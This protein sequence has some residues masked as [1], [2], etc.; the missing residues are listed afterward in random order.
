MLIVKNLYIS[1]AVKIIYSHFKFAS[2]WL[3]QALFILSIIA[4]KPLTLDDY[5]YPN[6]GTVCGWLV[7]C[8]SIIPIPLYMIYRFL[9]KVKGPIRQVRIVLDSLKLRYLI[10]SIHS[11]NNVVNPLSGKVLIVRSS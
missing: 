6:W 7:T 2:L 9:F 8:S 4:Y 3:F 5:V 11:H 1:F 10:N